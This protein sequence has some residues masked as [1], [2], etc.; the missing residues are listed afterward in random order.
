MAEPQAPLFVENTGQSQAK[1]RN[2]KELRIFTAGDG[3]L[4]QTR[5]RRRNNA[6]Q[7]AAGGENVQIS[8]PQAP[9]ITEKSV[10]QAPKSRFSALGGGHSCYPGKRRRARTGRQPDAGRT[11]GIKET[12]TGR[13]CSRGHCPHPPHTRSRF[14][15]VLGVRDPW[16]RAPRQRRGAP[17]AS[18]PVWSKPWAKDAQA[19]REIQGQLHH[20]CSGSPKG[21]R[22]RATTHAQAP[23]RAPAG[24]RPLMLRLP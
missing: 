4:Q 21:T 20:S 18:S 5:R 6:E 7:R 13:G 2:Y 10:P 1:G 23:Q 19:L 17:C 11:T 24:E 9:N 3:T 12:G 16:R 15:V 22:R 8:A 14:V